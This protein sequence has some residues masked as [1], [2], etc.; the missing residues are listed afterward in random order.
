MAHWATAGS[1]ALESLPPCRAG[2]RDAAKRGGRGVTPPGR[3]DE[4]PHAVGGDHV[5]MLRAVAVA[6]AG[7]EASMRFSASASRPTMARPGRG[8]CRPAAVRGRSSLCPRPSLL[9]RPSLG[10]VSAV[11]ASNPQRLAGIL[12]SD[13]GPS[14]SG[15]G[16]SAPGSGWR[17]GRRGRWS[18]DRRLFVEGGQRS[19][20]AATGQK[21]IAVALEGRGKVGRW[22]SVVR[23]AASHSRAASSAA[24]RR[25]DWRPTLISLKP[26][27]A[28]AFRGGGRARRRRWFRR[29]RWSIRRSASLRARARCKEPAQRLDNGPRCAA[30]WP[31]CRPD[32]RSADRRG[33]LR[34][35]AATA[36]TALPCSQRAR[37]PRIAGVGSLLG[38]VVV[39]A[40]GGHA[41]PRVVDRRWRTWAARSKLPAAR[42]AK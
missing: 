6:Q 28:I 3:R 34:R 26:G 2:L 12:P 36:R 10:I 40:D 37:A 42:S 18:A 1:S 13:Q 7:Q 17:R 25:P 23:A 29:G 41:G 32:G 35:R 31:R 24:P 5:G 14:A 9:P 38:V 11:A 20:K 33:G 27:G 15:L 8:R 19:L 30:G 22:P 21:H 39:E 4:S 16:S